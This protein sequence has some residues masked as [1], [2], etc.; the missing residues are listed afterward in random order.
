MASSGTLGR[1]GG[2][3]PEVEADCAVGGVLDE[4][5]V[6]VDAVVVPVA[7]ELAVVQ[8]GASALAPGVAGVV[9]FGLARVSRTDT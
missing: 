4:V 6:V 7:E 8:V 9:G 5:A 3:R 1:A 2:L